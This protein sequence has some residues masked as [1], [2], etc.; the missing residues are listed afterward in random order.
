MIA[1]SSLQITA[2]SRS[3]LTVWPRSAWLSTIGRRRP[4][5]TIERARAEMATLAAR[6]ER[7]D[8]GKTWAVDPLESSP[9]GRADAL[10]AK[11]LALGATALLL[12]ACN[13][14]AL[15]LVSRAYERQRDYMI[16]IHLGASRLRL[17]FEVIIEG[18]CLCFLS[19][20]GAVVVAAAAWTLLGRVLPALSRETW[21]SSRSVAI[22]A[23]IAVVSGGATLLAPCVQVIRAATD[24]FS[25]IGSAIS[26]DRSLTR[27]TLVAL[28]F[29]LALALAVGAHVFVRSLINVRSGLAYD[30]DEVMVASADF[31]AAGIRRESAQRAILEEAVD[32]LRQLPQISSVGISTTA[33]LGTAR[34]TTVLPS[35]RTGDTYIERTVNYVSPGYFAAVG[36]AILKGRA[37]NDRDVRGAPVVAIV[38]EGLARAEWP[39]L[40]VVGTCVTEIALDRAAGCV[41]IVGISAPRR[42]RRLT[43]PVGEVFF[44]LA[45]GDAVVPQAIFIRPS[46]SVE[47]ALPLVSGALHGHGN[48]NAVNVQPLSDLVDAQAR[49]WIVGSRVFAALGSLAEILAAVGIYG[50][51]ALSVR[52]RTP[53]IGI[54]AAL[55]ADRRR[56]ASLVAFE[57]AAPMAAG[58]VVGL[59]AVFWTASLSRSYLF[60]VTPTD[61]A[62][63]S[64]ASIVLV[65]SGCAGA[66]IPT[67]RAMRLSPVE[68][69]RAGEF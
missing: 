5:V 63:V 39:N 46:V 15:L 67:V 35:L 29:A 45:Q 16:R 4:G 57:A 38:D 43:T 12:V 40:N 7:R 10:L 37:F 49:L 9:S 6:A 61:L 14:V 30:I 27:R 51:L 25:R 36:T 64:S 55:G 32:S 26:S 13:N 42:L 11:L 34:F 68:A 21:L 50:T 53:E 3:P 28:Q 1:A 48:L 31:R 23:G 41:Q 20:M 59:L 65:L 58:W 69:L 33:P 19:M 47:Q 24:K 18:A 54:R 56:I 2:G 22:L 44:P 66:L 62:S 52:R 60:G 17:L 8:S